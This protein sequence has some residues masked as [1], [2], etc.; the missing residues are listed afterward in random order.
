MGAAVEGPDEASCSKPKVVPQ[1]VE[2]CFCF[3]TET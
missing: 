3:L 2:V 1:P